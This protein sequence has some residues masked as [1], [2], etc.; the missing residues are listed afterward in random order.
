MRIS[1]MRPIVRV[2][3]WPRNYP[4]CIASHAEKQEALER[5]KAVGTS[6]KKRSQRVNPSMSEAPALSRNHERAAPANSLA[7]N[8]PISGN[9]C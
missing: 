1:D 2:G 5:E 3:E 6:K 8:L 9:T 4:G 7:G